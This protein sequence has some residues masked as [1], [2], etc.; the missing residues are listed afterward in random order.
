MTT[1]LRLA[2][3]ASSSALVVLGLKALAWWLTGS[4]ALLSDALE[5]TV[6]VVTALAALVAIRVAA[7]PADAGHPYGHP[8]PSSS[9]AVLEGVMIIVAALLILR[10]AWHGLLAPRA[11]DAPIEG[12]LVSGV[13]TALNAAWCWVL[14]SRGRRAAV[15]RAGGGRAAPPRRRGDLGGRGAGRAARDRRP[16]GGCS[17]RRWRRWWRSTSSGRAGRWSANR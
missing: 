1:T 7:R 13:A 8:R 16:A 5:S 15:A 3:A 6:N 4:V 12:L 9:R 10:E 14:L 2:P 17:T 11:L